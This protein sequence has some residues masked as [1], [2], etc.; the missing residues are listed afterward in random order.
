MITSSYVALFALFLVFLSFRVLLLRRSK[1][2][3]VGTGGDLTLERAIRVHSNFTEYVPIALL[4]LYFTEQSGTSTIVLHSL[5]I[6]LLLGRIVHAY[7][8]SQ[9]DENYTF[10]VFGMFLT[11]GVLISASIRLLLF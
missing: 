6:A 7:G 2:V 1:G 11:F 3:G 4:L 8:V 9:V 5:F 10:R